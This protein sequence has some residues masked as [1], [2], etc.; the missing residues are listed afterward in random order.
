VD[1][2]LLKTA[3]GSVEVSAKKTK[4]IPTLLFIGVVLVV[5]GVAIASKIVH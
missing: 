5:I 3:A 4:K 2:A 1:Q